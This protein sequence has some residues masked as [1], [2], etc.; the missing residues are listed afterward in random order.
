MS[1][2]NPDMAG[3][4]LN[5]LLIPVQKNGVFSSVRFT[6]RAFQEYFLATAIIEDGLFPGLTLPDSVGDWIQRLGGPLR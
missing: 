5:S 6:H 2:H 1:L 3:L 4:V